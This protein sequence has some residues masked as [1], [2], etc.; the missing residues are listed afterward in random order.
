MA[1]TFTPNLNLEKPSADMDYD[2]SVPN[3]NMDKIDALLAR[4]VICTST[5]R[6]S[7]PFAGL[8]AFESDTGLLIVRNAANTAWLLYTEVFTCTSGT[9]PTATHPGMLIYETDTNFMLMR[10]STNSSWLFNLSGITGFSTNNTQ[11][12]TTSTTFTVGSGNMPGL[13]YTVPPS[14]SIRID[15][16]ARL[17]PNPG[18]ANQSA[19]YAP[20]V[21][22]GN[23]VGGGT[24]LSAAADDDAVIGG[25]A[26]GSSTALQAFGRCKIV[27]GLT[28]GN[29]VNVQMAIRS[30]HVTATATVESK[31]LIVSAA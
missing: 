24:V 13:A 5:T 18:T 29:F 11:A 31:K 25:G 22:Q 2:V 16:S 6:P 23:V 7:S 21:R 4:V 15:Y 1:S 26:G 9:H 27:P 19:Y 20:V 3:A 30:S 14:G 8:M 28:A 12:T 10:D 17:F